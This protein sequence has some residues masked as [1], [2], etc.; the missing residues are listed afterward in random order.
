VSDSLFVTGADG[1]IG[2]RLLARLGSTEVR[3]LAGDLRD[4]DSY[5]GQLDHRTTVVHLAARTGKAPDREY[6]EVNVEGTR[7]LLAACESRGVPRFLYVSTIAT[8]FDSVGGY[9]YAASK[10]QA[11]EL[12]RTCGLDWAIVRPTIVL[13]PGSA[14]LDGF[15][16]LLRPRVVLLP[17]G[18]AVRMQ[19]IHV[20]DVADALIRLA[21][22]GELGDRT[23]ELGGPEVLTLR[24]FL[25]RAH[26]ALYGDAGPRSVPVPIGP[27][28]GLLR[29][30]EAVAPGLSPVHPGQLSAFFHDTVATADGNLADQR[31]D[32]RS[33][34][35][36][37]GAW[38]TADGAGQPAV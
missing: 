30:A 34:E 14:A 20:D 10:L 35:T 15:R 5:V 6:F 1:F 3:K 16:P 24:E 11:E 32:L 17:G 22:A 38:A 9:P 36:M 21:R 8:T 27:I 2:G 26:R 28:R 19:P 25:S 4:T 31:T 29:L 23:H 12:V 37:L 7:H 18:G 13:G 33:I